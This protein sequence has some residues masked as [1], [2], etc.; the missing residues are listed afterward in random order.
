MSRIEELKKQNP[1]L[2]INL[3]DLVNSVIPKPKY[4]ELMINLI[5]RKSDANHERED[6]I[7][8]LESY[9]VN[10]IYDKLSNLELLIFFRVF[11]SYIGSS[12]LNTIKKF[13]E[14][15]ERNLI[16]NNNLSTYK[17]FDELR[18]QISLS[19]L[20]LIDKDIEK[21]VI[22]LHETSE[23]LVLKPLS[24]NSSRKYGANTKWCTSS[25]HEPDYFYKYAK[26]G[27]LIYAIDKVTGNKVAGYY[28]ISG[29][30]DRE[31]SFW[32]ILDKRIDSMEANL[33]NEIMSIFRNE[34]NKEDKVSNWALLSQEDQEKQ[35][36]WLYMNNYQTKIS[37][38]D[39]MVVPVEE[40]EIRIINHELITQYENDAQLTLMQVPVMRG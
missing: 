5:K 25:E 1:N 36:S 26:R 30:D 12:D 19:E 8:A 3:I 38:S 21:Q 22:K 13:I 18:L 31:L 28:Q 16:I 14:L 20:K 11:D 34:F 29:Y 33:P 23:W 15:N 6:I 17:S 10:M 37:Y 39:D 7:R 35:E 40:Q 9:D 24:W 4:T 27:V 2:N 32:N